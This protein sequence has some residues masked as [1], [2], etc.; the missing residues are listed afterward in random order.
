MVDKPNVLLVSTDHWPGHLLGIAGHPCM[1]TPT[2]DQL[3]RCGT[4]FRRAYSECPIC[5][6]ARRTLMTGTTPRSHGDRVYKDR[7]PMPEFPTLARVFGEAGYQ[8]YAVGKL[9]VYPQ[10]DR[11]GFDDVILGEEGRLQF[12]AVDDYE[13]FLGDMG[14]AGQ[15]FFHGMGNNEYVNRP[16]HLP[17]ECHVTTW[18][19]R[20][21][22]RTIQRRD[23]TRPGFW[24]LSY[25]HPHPP[26]APLECY[27]DV[28]R[29]LQVDTPSTGEWADDPVSLPPLLRQRMAQ[30]ERFTDAQVRSA[31]RAFYALCTQI[32]HQLRV[33]I[34]TLREQD[35]LENTIILFTAD[36]GDMLGEHGL[37]GKSQ[38]YEGAAQ[39]PMILVGS[40]GDDR[41][42]SGLVDDRLVGWQ[43]VMPT[44]LDLAGI[45]V[46][47]TVEGRSM[48]GEKRE[49]LYGEHGEEKRANR[50]MHDGRHKLIYY[51]AG[52][53]VQLFDLEED[54]AELRD[55]SGKAD[56]AAVR[57]RLE[58]WLIGELYGGDEAW[59]RDGKMVGLPDEEFPSG[60]NRG[61]SG[62]RGGHWPPPPYQT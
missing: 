22:V 5:I 51:P 14:Y 59:V 24:F 7:L 44:L 42:A 39:I 35:L 15:Q 48:V 49:F 12:G 16:W 2:L 13:L 54:P 57:E 20:Q 9:H 31:R 4:R 25:C 32:D 40:S 41:V 29:E 26:L 10:R 11:I 1:Q 50:M 3:G 27:L 19:T 60:G 46:P 18:A 36:H 21:M 30:G 33:V 52:N 6:P 34:G 17:E 23:P 37:W 43:D 56:Y 62:Q 55:L 58:N 38:F 53:C 8:T 61:L 45:D 28:Y 47:E